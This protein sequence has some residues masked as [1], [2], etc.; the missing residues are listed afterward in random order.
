MSLLKCYKL[1]F[2]F[3]AFITMYHLLFIFVFICF[4]LEGRREGGEEEGKGGKAQ[5]V[6]RV[7]VACRKREMVG[8]TLR[9]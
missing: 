4:V 5:V 1:F 7:R 6:V 2:S 8:K 9:N 3:K